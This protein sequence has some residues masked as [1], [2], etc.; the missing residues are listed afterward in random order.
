MNPNGRVDLITPDI[1]NKFALQDRITK[2]N[3][4][5]DFRDAM[6][7]V[8]SESTLS[9]SYFSKQNQEIIQNALRAEIYKKSEGKFVIGQQDYEQ[10][11]IVMRGI[12]LQNSQNSEKDIPGQI[13]KLNRLVLDYC[14]PQ[15]YSEA[16]A[17][18]KYR[19]DV[20]VLPT[21]IDLPSMSNQNHSKQLE[22]KP[23]F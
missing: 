16:V 6:T 20:S 2:I 9:R 11:Q 14:I 3:K 23:W 13:A 15:V 10:L 17:F 22:L 18:I 12:Y 5:T 8:W 19:Y 21:P 1:Q 7:G 4:A